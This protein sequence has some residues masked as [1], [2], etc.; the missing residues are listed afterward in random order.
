MTMP[1]A[2]V[3]QP[4]IWR[5]LDLPGMEHCLLTE[6]GTSPTLSG[7]VIIADRGV[8]Y[9]IE[10]EVIVDATWRTV[11]A[12]IAAHVGSER[13]EIEIR[14]DESGRWSVDGRT[15]DDLEGCT[16]VDLGFSP[17]TNTLPIRR[18]RLGVGAHAAIDAAWVRFPAFDVQRLGQGYTRLAERRYRYENLA[19]D[20][21]AEIDV[22][23]RGL[24]LDYPPAWERVGER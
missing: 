1:R 17:S 4:V 11:A 23:S 3:V 9:R 8:A 7:I 24:V 13:R 6:E 12:S 21:H 2:D 10:Y 20:F 19:G 16:D 5:R 14:A 15:R 22:D 18:L